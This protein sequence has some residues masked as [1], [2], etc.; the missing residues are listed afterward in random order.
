MAIAAACP[1]LWNRIFPSSGLCNRKRLQRADT[2]GSFERLLRPE[3]EP[4][5]RKTA[6]IEGLDSR[7]FV[8]QGQFHCSTAMA[9]HFDA[10]KRKSSGFRQSPFFCE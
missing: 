9:V 2:D 3:F 7:S 10:D 5:E 6:E 1:A 8:V 4:D